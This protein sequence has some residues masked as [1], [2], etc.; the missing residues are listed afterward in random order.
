MR[1][2]SLFGAVLLPLGVLLLRSPSLLSFACC[3][4]PSLGFA[5]ARRPAVAFAA[6]PRRLR[7]P[8]AA[9]SAPPTACGR[10]PCRVASAP[11]GASPLLVGGTARGLQRHG[12]PEGPANLVTFLLL[13]AFNAFYILS[14][15]RSTKGKSSLYSLD[16]I[17]SP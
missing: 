9:L 6:P 2:R 16:T 11:C 10:G 12:G 7:A 15:S 17:E 3:F 4:P 13:F 8:I 1:L 5:F 14:A